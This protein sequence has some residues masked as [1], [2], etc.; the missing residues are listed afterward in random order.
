[1]TRSVLDRLRDIVHSADLAS[2]YAADLNADALAEAP[3][4]RDATVFRIAVIGEAAAH[5]PP[6]IQALASEIPWIQV[7]AMRNHLIHGYWQVDFAIVAETVAQD[8]APL[9]R[10]ATRLIT[11]LDRSG[12]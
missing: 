11:L 3:P 5:L 8:L 7:K 1:M 2:E 4:R 12:M 9:K 10:A 6:E